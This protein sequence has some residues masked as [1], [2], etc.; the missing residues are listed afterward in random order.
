MSS[1]HIARKG[2][3]KH[4]LFAVFGLLTLFVLY[5]Y[6]VPLL[7]SDSPGRQRIAK[8]MW[9]MLPHGIAGA[10]ALFLGLPQFSDRLRR[11]SPRLH[12]ILGR[13]YVAGVAVSA[14]TAIPIAIILGP[15]SLVMAAT[16]QSSGWLL[17]TAIG[18]YCA[19]SGDIR[20][21]R[22]WMIRSYPFAMVFVIA[23]VIL[24]IPAVAA[25]GEVAFISVVWSLIAAAC[26]IPSLVINW[27]AVF[28]RGAARVPA[29]RVKTDRAAAI[30]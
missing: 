4:I 15:P 21:H 9:L 2:R 17:T 3:A 14:P 16:I 23:R 5:Y 27:N 30:G 18:L 7:D 29:P 13:V 12:R 24:A 22:E 20:Q 1:A 10:L 26:F 8:V 11:R 25:M 28:R 6:E 19:R